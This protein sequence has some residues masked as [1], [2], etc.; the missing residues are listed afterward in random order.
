VLSQ[1]GVVDD[2][3]GTALAPVAAL[4]VSLLTFSVRTGTASKDVAH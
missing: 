3:L 4:A 1:I 2:A